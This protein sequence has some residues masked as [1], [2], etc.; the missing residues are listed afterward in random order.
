MA[1]TYPTGLDNFTNPNSSDLLTSPSHSQQHSDIN[2]A[3][4]ALEA[5][6]G[7]T[8]STVATS[9]TNQIS[10]KAPLAS[11]TFTGTPTLPTGTIATTQT[12]GNSTTAVAT[13]A[14]ITT[15]DQLMGTY[16]S[17]TPT[18]PS[19]LTVGNAT[20]SAQYARVNNFVH[21]WGRVLWG[22]T[23]SINTSGLQVSLPITADSTFANGAVNTIG[24]A[25][26][27]N[28]TSSN[29]FFLT[30]F[31]VNG[32]ATAMNITAQLASGTYVTY[33]NITTTVP[34]TQITGDSF[35]WNVYYKAA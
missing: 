30:P 11:P 8:G 18:Y 9:L 33:S 27:K 28:N 3:V 6:A 29:L 13:T 15:A 4:E 19:G 32:T 21:Y 16:T 26:M 25:G 20:V 17:Y 5:Y 10:L 1:I 22:S 35:W 7:V 12:A 23:T 14:F 24:T 34:F 31:M 2:D